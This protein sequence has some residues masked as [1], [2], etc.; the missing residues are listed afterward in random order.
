MRDFNA[1]LGDEKQSRGVTN[2][3]SVHSPRGP[4]RLRLWRW[5]ERCQLKACMYTEQLD[6]KCP[7][8][9]HTSSAS[10]GNQLRNWMA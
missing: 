8:V 5:D 6:L 3:K 4:R 9:P 7:L 10:K 1:H 2:G